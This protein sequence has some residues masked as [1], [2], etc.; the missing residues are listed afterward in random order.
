MYFITVIALTLLF[1]IGTTIWDM[2]HSVDANVVLVFGKWTAFF[3]AG[4]RL[5][6]AGLRQALQPQFTLKQIFEIEDEAAQP[7][8]QELGFANLAMGAMGLFAL[9][10]P[11]LTFASAL[12]GGLFYGLAGLKHVLS[13]QRTGERS[14]AMATD[15]WV[16][17]VLAAYVALSFGSV[18]SLM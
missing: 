4:V 1:P 5:F 9:L 6:I 11:L 17:V 16:F 2:Q 10:H 14:V 3:A 18:A 7:I 8:V 12:M 13:K 15:I